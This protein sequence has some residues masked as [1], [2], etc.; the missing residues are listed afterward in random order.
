MSITLVLFRI[1]LIHV[2]LRQVYK[3]YVSKFLSSSQNGHI[4][5]NHHIALIHCSLMN[6]NVN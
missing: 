2:T 5:N 6:A 4:T 1:L 3:L